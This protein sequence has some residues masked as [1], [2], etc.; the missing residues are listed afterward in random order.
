MKVLSLTRWDAGQLVQITEADFELL[1][2][3]RDASLVTHPRHELNVCSCTGNRFPRG[4]Y[5]RRVGDRWVRLSFRDAERAEERGYIVTVTG[6]QL[7]TQ[8]AVRWYNP[9]L[10]EIVERGLIFR[11][12]EPGECVLGLRGFLGILNGPKDGATLT[13]TYHQIR[14]FYSEH[15]PGFELFRCNEHN[16]VTSKNLFVF[17]NRQV[18]Q[19]DDVSGCVV[20]CFRI[21]YLLLSNLLR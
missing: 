1:L 17:I 19:W 15:F 16:L 18:P 13:V 2:G 9:A 10:Y 5:T 7:V 8:V 11:C 21:R 12:Q 14:T 3:Q 20:R 6:R 4:C